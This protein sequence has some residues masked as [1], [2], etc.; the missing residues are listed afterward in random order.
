M[1]LIWKY[2]QDIKYHDYCFHLLELRFSSP[3]LADS[4]RVIYAELNHK[5]LDNANNLD[6]S[7]T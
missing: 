1:K 2:T 6:N 4:L 5:I 7:D 3:K